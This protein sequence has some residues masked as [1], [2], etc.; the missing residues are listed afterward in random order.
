MR[1]LAA[2]H[3]HTADVLGAEMVVVVDPRAYQYSMRESPQSWEE[4]RYERLGPHV[5]EPF[6]YFEQR[7]AALP[8]PVISLLEDFRN[9]REFP[10]FMKKDPHWNEAGAAFAAERVARAFEAK[11]LLPCAAPG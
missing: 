5:R 10:L 7:R 11:G 3:R 2:M 8:Y 4:D 1:H 6:R 9:A